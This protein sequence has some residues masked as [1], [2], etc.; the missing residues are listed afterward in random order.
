MSTMASQGNL[1]GGWLACVV[2]CRVR[3]QA[4]SV[5]ELA[6][7]DD[8]LAPIPDAARSSPCRSHAPRDPTQPRLTRQCTDVGRARQMCTNRAQ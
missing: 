6:P 3:V 5:D 1:T 7:A 4:V 8:A 2:P